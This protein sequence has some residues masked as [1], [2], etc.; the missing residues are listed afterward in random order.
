MPVQI[1]LARPLTP[2]FKPS[3]SASLPAKFDVV[4][5]EAI[6]AEPPAS[7]A[8]ASARTCSPS[9]WTPGSRAVR[10]PQV[11]ESQALEPPGLGSAP[12]SEPQA[13]GTP[14]SATGAAGRCLVEQGQPG[15][16]WHAR[17]AAGR[18]RRPASALPGRAEAFRSNSD[19]LVR[20]RGLEPPRVA[21]LAPQ[22][23]ASTNSAMAAFGMNADRYR[24]TYEARAM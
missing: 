4:P 22:A 24:R 20:P 11:Q 10:S 7:Q 12:G 5:V 19:R 14:I 8:P 1:A 18:S 13:V 6:A 16:A 23:S 21:P 9:T 15:S 17:R 3:H 2:G